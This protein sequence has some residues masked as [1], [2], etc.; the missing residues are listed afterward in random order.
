MTP[1]CFTSALKGLPSSAPRVPSAH[2]QS[3]MRIRL[4]GNQR[5][6]SREVA[7]MVWETTVVVPAS[8]S[9]RLFRAELRGCAVYA[10]R[11]TGGSRAAA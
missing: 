10:L 6:L 3:A 4:Q 11:K 7:A 5:Q 1:F 8:S 9:A 2:S